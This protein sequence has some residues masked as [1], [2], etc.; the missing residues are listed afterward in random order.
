VR[1]NGYGLVLVLFLQAAFLHGQAIGT[2]ELVNG[3]VKISS[4]AGWHN[5]RIGETLV[6]NSLI[7]MS[8]SSL[9]V[10]RFLDGEKK[11]L[12]PT[13]RMDLTAM[14]LLDKDGRNRIS[15]FASVLS[16]LNRILRDRSVSA[17][18]GGGGVRGAEF[19]AGSDAMIWSDGSLDKSRDDYR[20]MISS[21]SNADYEASLRKARGLSARFPS[22]LA[23]KFCLAESYYG[24]S[25]YSNA[26]DF[27][28]EVRLADR[29]SALGITALFREGLCLFQTDDFKAGG[30]DFR[31][32][33]ESFPD[34][35]DAAEAWF[36]L[37]VCRRLLGEK[38]AAKACF[39]TVIERFP[40][41]AELLPVVEAEIRNLESSR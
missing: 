2:V 16:K 22:S 6:T 24:L 41:R 17:E 3:R 34:D 7:R 10:L 33:T 20:S 23:V 40:S 36:F 15:G 30:E 14:S 11:T 28:R 1:I 5:C 39:R 29:T 26:A 19:A 27:F 18:G 25:S 37:G 4:G 12:K 35:A 31:L 21:L 8:G 32:F 38:D 9:L 13:G